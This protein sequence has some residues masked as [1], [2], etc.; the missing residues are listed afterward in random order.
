MPTPG[1]TPEIIWYVSGTIISHHSF[2]Y[3]YVHLMTK[4]D[5]ESI[6]ESKLSFD[7]ALNS[8][9]VK[10]SHYHAYNRLFDIK[11]FQEFFSTAG[12][13]LTFS[14]VNGHHNNSKDDNPIKD[15]RMSARTSLTH[16]VHTC[17]KSLDT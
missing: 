3:T 13:G 9:G 2:Y 14:G 10:V 17:Q 15:M 4:M 7:T 5:V 8:F 1:G 12:Q 6:F 11:S 16:A